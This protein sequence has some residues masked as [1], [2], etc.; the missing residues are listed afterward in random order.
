MPSRRELSKAASKGPSSNDSP[1]FCESPLG[2]VTTHGSETGHRDESGKKHEGRPQVVGRHGH[3]IVSENPDGPIVGLNAARFVDVPG[4]AL[5][6]AAQ[7]AVGKRN[8]I[9]YE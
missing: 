7:F 5:A 1:P 8:D 9:G 4:C 6:A 3:T 2:H